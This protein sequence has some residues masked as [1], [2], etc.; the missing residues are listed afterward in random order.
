M[1]AQRATKGREKKEEGR[2]FTSRFLILL[3]VISSVVKISSS[4]VVQWLTCV[5]LGE[6]GC[7]VPWAI[8]C[9]TTSLGVTDVT[10]QG[11]RNGRYFCIFQPQYLFFFNKMKKYSGFNKGENG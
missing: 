5:Q 7:P 2:N 6:S 11:W 3:V 10:V 9:S 1:F 4:G 8:P